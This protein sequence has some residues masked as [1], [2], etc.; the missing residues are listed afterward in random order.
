LS[1][2]SNEALPASNSQHNPANN[3]VPFGTQQQQTGLSA[4]SS[5]GSSGN[6]PNSSE[7]AAESRRQSF[8]ASTNGECSPSSTTNAF[9][10]PLRQTTATTVI[11]SQLATQA[12]GAFDIDIGNNLFNP[13]MASSAGVHFQQVAAP[14]AT[15]T[16]SHQHSNMA[17][18]NHQQRNQYGG[19]NDLRKPPN[20]ANSLM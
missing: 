6:S 16:S 11:P 4:S 12:F 20:Y 15:M 10:M 14:H 8:A 7:A 13:V 18:V 3:L 17:G 5:L 2:N 9:G 1:A 19:I